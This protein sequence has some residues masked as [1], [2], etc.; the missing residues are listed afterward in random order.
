MR[1]R[2]L[3]LP[4][5]LSGHKY[6]NQDMVIGGESSAQVAMGVFPKIRLLSVIIEG[7]VR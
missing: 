7:R 6:I 4:N 1:W 2:K 3:P 5:L